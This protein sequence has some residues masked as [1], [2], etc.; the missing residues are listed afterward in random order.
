MYKS[1]H[2]FDWKVVPNSKISKIPNIFYLRKGALFIRNLIK[3][4]EQIRERIENYSFN[5]YLKL[6]NNDAVVKNTLT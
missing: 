1:R 4:K 5:P 6:I 3:I 2:K